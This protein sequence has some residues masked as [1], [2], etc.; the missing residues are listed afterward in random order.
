MLKIVSSYIRGQN[1]SIIV[2]DVTN[3]TSYN[4]ISKWTQLIEEKNPN[5]TTIVVLGNKCDLYEKREV[6]REEAIKVCKE[7]NY[8]YAECSALYGGGVFDMI[9]SLASNL[10]NQSEIQKIISKDDNIRKK[11]KNA[12]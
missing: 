3:R 5:I 8:M 6:S 2:F 10:I 7:N 11:I 12:Y 9:Y 4:S 1:A